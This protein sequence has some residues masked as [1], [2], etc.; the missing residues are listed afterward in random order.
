MLNNGQYLAEPYARISELRFSPYR[1]V[2]HYLC[3]K[4]KWPRL[5]FKYKTYE[6]I[7]LKDIV[8]NSCFYMSSINQLND[9]FDSQ[10]NILFDNSG[11]S[12]N[13]YLKSLIKNNK[14]PYKERARL[15]KKLHSPTIIQ[16]ELQKIRK[17]IVDKTGIFSFSA[18]SKNLLLWSH[19]SNSHKGVCLIFDIAQDLDVFVQSLPIEYS[20]DYPEIQ[21]SENLKGDL[22]RATFLTKANDWLYE[23]ERRIFNLDR[24]HQKL[25]FNPKALYGIILGAKSDENDIRLIKDLVAQRDQLG[26]P[27]LKI[28]LSQI[29]DSKYKVV[30]K[31]VKNF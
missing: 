1:A 17:N 31:R 16:K 13:N 12:R 2:R 5:L 15:E 23:N 6:P 19:Y 30:Y 11:V 14:L 29:S 25:A 20:K 22:I 10:S 7:H 9:P 21:Y 3:K 26:R 28:F 18:E 4:Q 27:K 24:A 8:V